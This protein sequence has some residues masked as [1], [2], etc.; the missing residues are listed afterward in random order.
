MATLLTRADPATGKPVTR[1]SRALLEC[2]SCGVMEIGPNLAAARSRFTLIR[3]VMAVGTGVG[4]LT[5]A[6]IELMRSVKSDSGWFLVVFFAAAAGTMVFML[7][8][9]AAH[10]LS[11][12][13][14]PRERFECWFLAV[15]WTAPLVLIIWALFGWFLPQLRA[16]PP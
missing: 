3:W 9:C 5:A 2:R 6:G 10:A 4:V 11:P 16:G 8:R 7:M 12:E 15:F 13:V 14:P 1:G